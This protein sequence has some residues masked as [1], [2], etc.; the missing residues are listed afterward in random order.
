V[1]VVII[2]SALS[3]EATRPGVDETRPT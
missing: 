2:G 3:D 1:T